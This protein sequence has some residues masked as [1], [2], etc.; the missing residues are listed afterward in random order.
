MLGKPGT[1]GWPT[2]PRQLRVIPMLA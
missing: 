1:M 2:R